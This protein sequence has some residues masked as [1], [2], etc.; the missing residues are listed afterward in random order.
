MKYIQ[1]LVASDCDLITLM[2]V[3]LFVSASA[4][5]PRAEAKIVYTPVDVTG[6]NI[7]FDVNHDGINDFE[8]QSAIGSFICGLRGGIRG[9]VTATP[10]TGDGIVVS[11]GNDAA[12]LKGGIRVGPG[13]TFYKSGV[14]MT[15]FQ[16]GGCGLSEAGNWCGSFALGCSITAYL[17]L[18]FLVNGHTHYGWAHVTVVIDV[19]NGMH[20]LT[21]TLKGF[22]YETI[23]GQ[24]I[25]T[26]Q[27]SGP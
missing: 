26:G 3:M 18:E 20:V 14:L 25:T 8:I 16:R 12:A 19:F 21:V 27:T 5:S 9:V 24:G 13:S 15:R 4:F 23:A 10:T 11:G 1:S 17:G 7:K 6:G 2:A 22:A